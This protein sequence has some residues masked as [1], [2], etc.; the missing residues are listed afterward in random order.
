MELELEKEVGSVLFLAKENSTAFVN[1]PNVPADY[2]SEPLIDQIATIPAI[3]KSSNLHN[4]DRLQAGSPAKN[5]PS[6]HTIAKKACKHCSSM[7]IERKRRVGW[8]KIVL[9][10]IKTYRYICYSCGGDFYAKRSV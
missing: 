8:E 1:A 10:V 4:E 7:N 6:N 9:P 5:N 3:V 2:P